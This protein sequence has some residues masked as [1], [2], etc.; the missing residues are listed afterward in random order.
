[1]P[2][3]ELFFITGADAL[4]QILGWKASDQ[5]LDL[6][7]FVGVT[8]PGYELKDH[9][10]PQDKVTLLEIPALAISSSQIRERV[11]T[12]AAIRY[13][14]PAGVAQYVEKRGLYRFEG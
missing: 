10:L 5:I 4:T 9:G 11:R 13:L 3:A 6:A 1:M 2:T 14:M 8:R 12:G 7:H